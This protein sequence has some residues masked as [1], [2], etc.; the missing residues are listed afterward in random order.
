MAGSRS[1]SRCRDI[2]LP[3]R[4]PQ[5]SG[6]DQ[7]APPVRRWPKRK[8]YIAA[9]YSVV[10]DLDLEN[11][12]RLSFTLDCSDREAISWVDRRCKI[13]GHPKRKEERAMDETDSG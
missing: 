1:A 3:R 13:V 8:R 11:F 6:S 5:G 7:D 4:R 2:C 9:G 12:S 10:V